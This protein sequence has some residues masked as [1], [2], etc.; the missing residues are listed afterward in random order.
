MNSLQSKGAKSIPINVEK[1]SVFN[2][3]NLSLFLHQIYTTGERATTI[4][5]VTLMQVI[6][7]L[8]SAC[9]LYNFSYLIFFSD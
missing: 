8:R 6:K 1:I 9:I 4:T 2:Y 3:T 5:Y 7:I